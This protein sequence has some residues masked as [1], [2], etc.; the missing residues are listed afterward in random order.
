MRLALCLALLGNVAAL[1]KVPPCRLAQTI[2]RAPEIETLEL[3]TRRTRTDAEVAARLH[4]WVR[5]G[6]ARI[7]SDISALRTHPQDSHA[8]AGTEYFWWQELDQ[9][10]D[11]AMEFPTRSGPVFIGAALT[12]KSENRWTCSFAPRAPLLVRW[13]V[14]W[15]AQKKPALDW[16]EQLDVFE[17]KIDVDVATPFA[18]TGL[19]GI[20]RPADRLERAAGADRWLHVTEVAAESAEPD[21]AAM[22]PPHQRVMTMVFAVPDGV[23]DELLTTHRESGDDALLNRLLDDVKAGGARLQMAGG[24]RNR[25]ELVSARRHAY[26]TEMHTFPSAWDTMSVGDSVTVGDGEVSVTTDLAPPARAEF[27]LSKSHPDFVLWWPEPLRAHLT[28]DTSLPGHGAMLLGITRMPDFLETEPADCRALVFIARSDHDDRL[29]RA[30]P[31]DA[32]PGVECEAQVFEI[33]AADE[34]QFQTEGWQLPDDRRLDA[35]RKRA[36]DGSARQIARAWLASTAGRAAKTS[37][38]QERCHVTECDT[39]FDVAPDQ[40]RPTALDVLRVGVE[41][42]AQASPL[43]DESDAKLQRFAGGLEII[44]H[45]RQ[46]RIPTLDEQLDSL[47]QNQGECAQPLLHEL[48]WTTEPDPA[49]GRI[50]FATGRPRCLGVKRLPGAGDAARRFVAFVSVQVVR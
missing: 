42:S 30:A 24:C 12:Y 27:P 9:D 3:L 17:E 38:I 46:P 39:D 43:T 6:R 49:T 47:R 31:R 23:V 18:G 41:F 29:I 5:A 2:I 13:P 19:L 35:L 44:C 21:N 50:V 16:T 36:A 10:F 1:A 33:D 37:V 34:A 7:V 20:C 40:Y 25:G 22:S 28:A 14:V 45:V 8:R 11:P 4:E 26:P 32:S 48:K 15:P